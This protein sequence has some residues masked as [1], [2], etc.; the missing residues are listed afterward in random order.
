LRKIVQ[1]Q[2]GKSAEDAN[3]YVE[4]LKTDKRYKRD[5]Y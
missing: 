4:K 1:E 2:G 5:V 3:T